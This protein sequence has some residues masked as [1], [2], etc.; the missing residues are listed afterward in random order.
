MTF[1]I[2]VRYGGRYQRYHTYA[3]TAEDA[4]DALEKAAHALPAEI[5]GQ[6]DLIEV[7]IA[8]DPEN[9]QYMDEV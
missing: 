9:R 7:R 3:V 2:T 5:V 8:V 6:V 4:R 1:Q